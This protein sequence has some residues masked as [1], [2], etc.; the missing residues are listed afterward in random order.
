LESIFAD[1]LRAFG[2]HRVVF[3]TDTAVGPYRGQILQEQL[4]ILERLG[5]SEEER[6]AVMGGNARRLFRL[7]APAA[8]G[9]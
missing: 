2:P 6:A 7:G 3:G 1:A 8:A 5:L 9:R 4:E